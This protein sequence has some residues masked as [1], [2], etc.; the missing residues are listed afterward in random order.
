MAAK[1]QPKAAAKGEW[2]PT[3]I[4]EEKVKAATGRGWM[5]WFIIMNR[6]NANAMPHKEI[7]QLLHDKGCPACDCKRAF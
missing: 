4:S 2:P 6:A 7:A 1:A 3:S 5:G